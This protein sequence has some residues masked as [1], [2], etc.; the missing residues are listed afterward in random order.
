MKK[1]PPPSDATNDELIEYLFFKALYQ[2]NAEGVLDRNTC[3]ALKRDF[4]FGRKCWDRAA[5]RYRKTELAFSEYR[6]NRTIENAD[7]A[8]A[9]WDGCSDG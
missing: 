9:S 3:T 4:L 1:M 7:K 5:E 6:K 2:S 8:V